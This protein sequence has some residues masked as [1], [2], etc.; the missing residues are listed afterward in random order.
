MCR[1]MDAYACIHALNVIVFMQVIVM[2][3]RY[4]LWTYFLS[5]VGTLFLI[6]FTSIYNGE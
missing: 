6:K 2:S 4:V 1:K 5:A 3:I